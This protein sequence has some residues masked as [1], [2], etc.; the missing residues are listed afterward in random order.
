MGQNSTNPFR[1]GGQL[2]SEYTIDCKS[3]ELFLTYLTHDK[4]KK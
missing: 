4:T 2:M 1:E 3:P